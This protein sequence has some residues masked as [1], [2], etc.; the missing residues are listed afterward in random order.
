ME[1]LEEAVWTKPDVV[2]FCPLP[3]FRGFVDERAAAGVEVTMDQAPF[4]LAARART[5]EGR[6]FLYRHLVRK[7]VDCEREPTA[8]ESRRW[9]RWILADVKEPKRQRHY[10]RLLPRG[11]TL[12]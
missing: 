2:R 1:A 7:R 5:T 6:A 4:L 9:T 12:Q 11:C 8:A 3:T 10:R